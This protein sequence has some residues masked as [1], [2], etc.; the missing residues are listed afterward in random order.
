MMDNVFGYPDAV[1]RR[2]VSPERAGGL[3][4]HD[5]VRVRARSPAASFVLELSFAAGPVPRARFRALGCPVTIAVGVWL[6][7]RLETQG[8]RA[9]RELDAPAI[10]AALEIPDERAHCA[11]MGE[12]A[13]RALEAELKS[14]VA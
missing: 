9:L 7:E 5:V 11:F 2:F 13:I 8:L 6:A 12:D 10:R 1:W 14:R 4:G 3:D